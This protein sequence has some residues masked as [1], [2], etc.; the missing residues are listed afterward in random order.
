MNP[1][2]Y[3]NDNKRYYTWNYYLKQRYHT[4]VCKI[5]LSGGFTCPNRDGN[6]G[7]G[8]CAFCSEDGSGEFAGNP[9]QSIAEQMNRGRE[10]LWKKWPSAKLIPYFQ[11]FS[12]TYAPVER[13]AELY[14]AALQE[15]DVVGLSVATRP[16]CL[17]NEVC[18]YLAEL[19][20]RTDLIVELGL[21]TA[22]DRTAVAMGRGHSFAE[23][24][25]G[26]R[27][28]S[29]R[30]IAVCIHLINGLPGEGAK[31]MLA[32]VQ[33]VAGL[34]PFAVKI[35]MLQILRGTRLGKLYQ[36]KPFSLLSRD[37]YLQILCDQ[38]ELLPPSTV[39]QRLTGDGKAENLIAPLWG[40][41]KLTLLNDLDKEFVRRDSMQGVRFC[42][43]KMEEE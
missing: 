27:K 42:S 31:D 32:T 36:K 22:N 16:D 26:Y 38:L 21:Q 1:F 14:E 24:L 12:G 18:D 13:L 3:S 8:G 7:I 19:S 23:F 10:R 29:E 37:E 35:H 6:C 15:K 40:Q 17:P 2:P 5:P 25:E 30:G 33:K 9:Q 34:T 11:S 28:L 4:K 20:R 43:K 39:I 41:K